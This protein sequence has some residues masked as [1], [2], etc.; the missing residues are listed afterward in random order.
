M[1]HV[2][3]ASKKMYNGSVIP[4]K[5]FCIIRGSRTNSAAPTMEKSLGKKSLT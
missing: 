3:L 1:R 4:N 5:E 2:E